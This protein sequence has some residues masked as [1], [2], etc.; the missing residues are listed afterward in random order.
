MNQRNP[1]PVAGYH[2]SALFC[3]RQ[4]EVRRL[5]ANVQNG[6]HTT[7]LS[8]RRMGKTGLLYHLFD[9]LGRKRNVFCIYADIYAT[10]NLKEFTGQLSSAAF[11]T[12]PQKKN[13]GR[14]LLDL[15]KSFRPIFAF[16]QLTGEPQVSFDYASPRQLEESLEGLFLFLDQ[17]EVTIVFAID[18]FQQ[19]NQYPE[20]NVEAF[21]RTLIQ[22]LKNMSFIFSGSS[23]DI[24]HQLFNDSKRPFFG[25][26]KIMELNSIEEKDYEA[27]IALHFK[28]HRRILQ[29]E[30][31]SFISSFTRLHTYYTQLLC[32]RLFADGYKN[33]SKEM[34]QLT[35]SQLLKEHENVFFQY[36]SLL[37]KAQ[38]QLLKAI[39]HE[40][41]LYKPGAKSFLS[42]H[43]VGT[44]SNVQRSLEGLL[45]KEMIY[46]DKDDDG[47]YYRVYDCLLARWLERL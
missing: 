42:K 29:R 3:N 9:K 38:W 34:V 40:D 13:I 22:P 39:A 30:A 26:S 20:K 4:D 6:V 45:T 15:L 28:Q 2:G 27:F 23:K 18:E 47:N 24:L 7:L 19:I 14:H 33:I 10:Q 21:L 31:L 17:Q 5:S 46:R 25:S 44:P 12:F 8:I 41:K 43:R 32:N 35:C 1:F 37:T 16:D 36:R 11:K